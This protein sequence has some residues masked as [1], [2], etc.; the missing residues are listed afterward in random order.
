MRVD[1][2]F[3]SIK[4]NPFFWNSSTVKPIVQDPIIA[5][6]E[7]STSTWDA[8]KDKFTK[9]SAIRISIES[10]AASGD[11]KNSW[12]CALPN[13]VQ[14][15]TSV[16]YY[17]LRAPIR[18][19]FK[20]LE[21]KQ[22]GQIFDK[23]IASGMDEKALD[24]INKCLAL[25]PT[26]ELKDML[27]N[28]ISQSKT[29]PQE[30][31]QTFALA[32]KEYQKL[33]TSS[34][35]STLKQHG[36][37][38]IKKVRNFIDTALLSYRILDIGKEPGSSWDA[39]E[40]LQAYTK[41]IAG[42][43]LIFAALA[44]VCS[45]VVALIVTAS[46]A[47]AAILATWVYTN[48]LQGSP[49]IIEPCLNLTTLALQGSL[50]PV[51]ARE[52][53]ID[54]VLKALAS[55]SETHRSHPLLC[56]PSG[57]GKTEIIRGIA[58]RL[59]TGNVPDCLKGKKLLSVNAAELFDGRSSQREPEDKLQR[60]LNRMDRHKND[61][62]VFFDEVHNAMK[63]QAG[64]SERL[65]TI[66]DT[67]P[68]ALMYCIAATTEAEYQKYIEPDL[69][70]CRRFQKVNVKAT[71]KSQ[72]LLILREMANCEAGHL[73]ISQKVLE[74]I[75][76]SSTLHMPKLQQPAAA[77][78]ILARVISSCAMPNQHDIT[79]EIQVK[80]QNVAL[81]SSAIRAEPDTKNANDDIEKMQKLKQEIND[82]KNAHAETSKHNAALHNMKRFRA[83]QISAMFKMALSASEDAS[84]KTSNQFLFWNYYLVPNLK[85]KIEAYQNQF[86][87][88]SSVQIDEALID[89]LIAKETG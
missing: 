72:T 11:A 46:I 57:V 36:T 10:L 87:S 43:L 88:G 29:T 9:K 55:S 69:A 83:E 51:L 13:I 25:I 86:A 73:E 20:S 70:F 75:Y 21:F 54:E 74:K 85:S 24:A 63:Q 27:Q 67:H 47:A 28:A 31:L 14:A 79:P 78:R 8:F 66:L 22:L 2:L 53:E 18:T 82:L 81:M 39:S 60:M 35:Q 17:V 50:K 16:D 71:N 49:D 61:Y 37:T 41:I 3:S 80:E 84:A 44:T 6:I 65:K 56:G 89:A 26:T 62:I 33:V 68:N 12:D 58:Q 30:A 40:R 4:W 59:A 76:E 48:W 1:S 15:L 77:I 34:A 7:K 32:E 42:P 5:E 52:A 23:L 19:I 64:A 38:V 45:V